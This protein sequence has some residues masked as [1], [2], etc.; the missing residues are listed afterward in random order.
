MF[1]LSY[2][3][4]LWQILLLAFLLR[5]AGVG[6]GLPLWIVG[7]EPPFVTATLKMMELKTVLPVLHQGEFK[8]TLYFPPY[9]SYLYL[10]PFSLMLG[11][12]Y[13]FFTGTLVAFKNFIVSDLSHFF[14]LARIIN[15]VLGTLTVWLVY[16]ISKNIFKKELAALLSAAFLAFST[17]HVYLSF[18]AR[19]W[20]PA[21]FLFVLAIWFLS[22]P[23]WSFKKR[24]IAGA[25]TSGVACGVSVIAGFSMLFILFWYLFYEKHSIADAFKE[26]ILYAALFIFLGL[27]AISVA[28]FPFGFHLSS[29]HSVGAGK[30]LLGFI[31]NVGNFFKPQLYS[32]PILMIFAALGLVFSYKKFRNLFQTTFLFLFSYAGIFYLVFHYEQRYTVYVFP[33]LALLAGYGLYRAMGTFSN[34][35]ISAGLLFLLII[36]LATSLQLNQLTLKND[37][38]IQAMEWAKEN[39]PANTKILTYAE[40]TRFITGKEAILEQQLL[41]PNSLRQID[42]AEIRLEENPTG[43]KNFHALNLYAINNDNFYENI[44]DYA[45]NNNYEYFFVDPIYP[46]ENPKKQREFLPL[47]ANNEP[48]KT[49]G[50]SQK[51][52][53]LRDGNFGSFFDFF[54]LDSFGPQIELY[55]LQYE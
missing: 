39:L 13:L 34:K 33:V 37:S 8:P 43:Y 25:L 32:E 12:K 47:V 18:V 1:R 20:V 3:H 50:S 14:I 6:Y 49:F 30:S 55:K 36:P 45:K 9:L 17:L 27:A 52:F 11:V 48:I 29:G 40:M 10:I 41:D 51:K 4:I 15:V 54:K 35:F 7:D 22:H 2:K 31:A 53:C 5:L 44:T 23:G 21:V 26:K 28:V 46:P 19:D 16:K 42:Y 38:R 24:Y